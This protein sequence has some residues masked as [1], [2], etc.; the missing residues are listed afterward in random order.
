MNEGLKVAVGD[1]LIV[2]NSD[3]KIKTGLSGMIN[4][5]ETEASIGLIALRIVNSQRAGQLSRFHY[6]PLFVSLNGIVRACC[7][8]YEPYLAGG[9]SDRRPLW[10]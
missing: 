1:V 4:Y 7:I 8:E 2:M 6:S 3:V 10:L 9:L 5:L